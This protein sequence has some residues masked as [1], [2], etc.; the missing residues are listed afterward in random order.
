LL[1]A[2]IEG[3]ERQHGLILT[4]IT[5]TENALK[6]LEEIK[7]TKD[8]VFSMGANVYLSST[9]N[10][11]KALVNIGAGV[12]LEKSLDGAIEIL[13]KRREELEKLLT[14]TQKNLRLA[15]IALQG[16]IPEIKKLV[17]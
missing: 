17:E 9:V 5:E 16:L 12:V 1:Q 2:R 10:T 7:K 13:Q 14:E 8:I 3:L 15:R 6:G 4:K 11:D